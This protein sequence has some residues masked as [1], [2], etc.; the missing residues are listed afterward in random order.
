MPGV[1]KTTWA[2]LKVGLM[3]I[4]ALSI[5]TFLIFLMVGTKGIFRSSS[6]VYTYLNDSQAVAAGADVR[7]NGILIGKVDTVELSGSAEPDRVVRVVMQIDNRYLSSVPVDS[8]AGLSAANL[9]GAKFINIKKGNAPQTIQPGA[10]IASS[11]TAELQDIFEQS[12]STLAALQI[13]ISKINGIVDSI[14]Q[15]KGT[16]GELLVN[17]DL[18]KKFLAIADSAQ[19]IASDGEKV[20]ATLNSNQNSVGKLL[21]DNNELYGQVRDGLDKINTTVDKINNGPGLISKLLNDPEMYDQARQILT[22][23][24]DLLAGIEAGQGTAGKF[25]KSDELH[26]Q[27]KTTLTQVNTL[28]DKMN[29]G[30]GAISRLLNDPTIAEDL[31]GVMRE[32]QG[33]L[34][35]FRANPKKFLHIKIGLF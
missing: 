8:Q 13:T 2:Q 20:V 9:L 24:H 10:E 35:D 4:A 32:T 6:T 28:L 11:V 19:I 25:L 34:K 23:V 12:S 5:L 3:A 27:L 29:N 1:S 16:I 21:H 26:D 18:Y 7:L 14:T 22:Q 30:Q 15:G 33:L 17:D 31:D